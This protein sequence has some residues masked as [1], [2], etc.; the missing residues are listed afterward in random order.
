M[1]ALRGGEHEGWHIQL[2]PQPTS[3]PE[4]C[5][6][7]TAAGPGQQRSFRFV[8]IDQASSRGSDES[9]KDGLELFKRLRLQ[10]LIVT[11]LHKIHVVEPFVAN[12]G[13]VANETGADSQLRN[14]SI[15]EYREE[16]DRPGR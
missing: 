11:P 14:M 12:V 8:V 7:G 15:H 10:L 4:V 5:E 9:A 6:L 16:R 1:T 2:E 3:D 13:F